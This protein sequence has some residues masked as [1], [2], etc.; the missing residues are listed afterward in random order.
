MKGKIFCIWNVFHVTSKLL[1]EVTVGIQVY[2][3]SFSAGSISGLV[4]LIN[5]IFN[6]SCIF[7]QPFSFMAVS[8]FL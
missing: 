2:L 3:A 6:F 4:V 8:D 7:I 1:L 5:Y